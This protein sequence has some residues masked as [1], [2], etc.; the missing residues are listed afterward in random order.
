MRRIKPVPGHLVKLRAEARWEE[1]KKIS[2][3]HG[4][5]LR[6]LVISAHGIRV[7]IMVDGCRWWIRRDQLEVI[8]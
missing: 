2:K 5:D 8:Q 6:G 1:F 4:L 3:E 7:E